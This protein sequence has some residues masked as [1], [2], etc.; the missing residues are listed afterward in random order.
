MRSKNRNIL[1]AL[2]AVLALGAVASASA[3]AALPEFKT[4]PGETLPVSFTGQGGSASWSGPGYAF[5]CR[6]T[7]MAGTISAAKSVTKGSL[8]FNGC[9]V[10]ANKCHS[11]GSENNEQIKTGPLEGTLAYISKT[12]KTAG[13]DFKAEGSEYW[14]TMICFGGA[15]QRVRGSIVMP[16]TS[17]NKLSTSFTLAARGSGGS[18]ED[19]SGLKHTVKLEAEIVGGAVFESL[20]WEFEDFLSTNRKVEIKA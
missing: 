2:V 9:K 16:I 12:A 7:S 3:S 20:S 18:Y 17:V 19:E 14:T 5:T 13:I 10:G 11:E 4:A 15:R 6:E 8:V 1:V